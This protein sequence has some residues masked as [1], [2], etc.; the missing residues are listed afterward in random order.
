[1]IVCKF[2]KVYGDSVNMTLMNDGKVVDT[3]GVYAHRIINYHSIS[4]SGLCRVHCKVLKTIRKSGI[5]KCV[6]S[7][8]QYDEEFKLFTLYI[9]ELPQ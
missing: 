1:M 5:S 2:E 8:S 3:L 7:W 9:E 6:N 4:N